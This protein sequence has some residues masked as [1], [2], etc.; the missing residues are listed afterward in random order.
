MKEDHKDPVA[1]YMNANAIPMTNAY[2]AWLKFICMN[3]NISADINTADSLAP[4][5]LYPLY[6]NPLKQNSSTKGASIAMAM[7]AI[8]Q[9]LSSIVPLASNTVLSTQSIDI[10]LANVPIGITTIA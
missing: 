10:A 3:A 4:S 6:T 8:Y 2:A 5:Y 7:S 1:S 9:S